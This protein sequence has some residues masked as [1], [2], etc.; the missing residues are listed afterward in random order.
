MDSTPNASSARA[1]ARP[2]GHEFVVEGRETLLEAGLKAGLR[3]DY[4]CGND[5]CG[6]CRARVIVGAATKVMAHDHPL[7]EADRQ[8]G[9][10]LLGAHSAGAGDR[11]V[12][13]TAADPEPGAAAIV[14]DLGGALRLDRRDVCIAGPAAF[15]AATIARLEVAGVPPRQVRAAV[16]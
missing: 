12:A 14:A 16:V 8:Q 15:V 5:T 13:H 6:L 11:H 1:T 2:S 4:G 9:L 3:L 7:S 10:I